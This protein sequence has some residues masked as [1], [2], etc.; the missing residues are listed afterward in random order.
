MKAIA[1]ND[2]LGHAPDFELFPGGVGENFEKP[3]RAQIVLDS[4]Q[5]AELGPV[6]DPHAFDESA[7]LA[8][9]DSGYYEFLCNAHEEWC[10]EGGEGSPIPCLWPL[11]GMRANK[12]EAFVARLGRYFFDG[13]VPITKGTADAV[14]M[15]ANIALTATETVIAGDRAAF[16]LCR[17][18]GHH[19]GS[20]F[21]GGYCFLNNAAIS[22]QWLLNSGASRVAI[23]DVDY[24]HGNGTQEIFYSRSDVF[25]ASI[26]GDPLDEYPYYLGYSDEVGSGKGEGFN[27]NI[28]LAKGTTFEKWQAALSHCIKKI[29]DYGADSLVVSLGLDTFCNDPISSFKLESE[30]YFKVGEVLAS[31]DIP[32]VLVFEGGYAVGDLGT[33]TANVLTGFENR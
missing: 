21:G 33:N 32:T 15:S 2:H 27:L 3:E 4:F 26:H 1:S 20:D 29:S 23:L 5:A 11:P 7:I 8:V 17:P 6:I 31:L 14:R 13:T 9:H 28:P 24:H 25:F 22:A 10:R 19:A 30:D 16:A 12:P 18:P